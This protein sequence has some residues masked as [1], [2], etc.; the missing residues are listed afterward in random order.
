MRGP[1]GR[2]RCRDE[3][4]RETHPPEPVPMTDSLPDGKRHL[5]SGTEN[6]SERTSGDGR[7]PVGLYCDTMF[8]FIKQ[9]EGQGPCLEDFENLE[10]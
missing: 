4:P 2:G 10:G 6:M 7:K 3:S 1:F 5:S 8:S 9:K